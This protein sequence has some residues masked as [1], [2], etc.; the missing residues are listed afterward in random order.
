MDFKQMYLIDVSANV[1]KKGKFKYLSW[2]HAWK[3]FVEQCPDATYVVLKDQ[4]NKCYFGDKD[5]GY[6]VY[7]SVTVDKITHEMW[8]PVMDY[9]N[10]AMKNPTM[11]DINKAVMRCLV[12]NLA[13]FG[14]GLNL[15][16]GE[17]L[18]EEPD[19][20]TQ[21]KKSSTSEESTKE[22]TTESVFTFGKNS[23]KK[24]S[25]VYSENASYFKYLSENSK[26]LGL[27]KLSAQLWKYHEE[28]M[29]YTESTLMAYSDK[30]GAI[31]CSGRCYFIK[32]GITCSHKEPTGNKFHRE[33]TAQTL[34]NRE[35]NRE[36]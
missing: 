31:H 28:G 6:M 4:N 10:K 3:W 17:D 11:M 26:D 9:S 33:P 22:W 16:A 13:M 12:K 24:V 8:L 36:H 23:G 35:R 27:K 30:S 32:N 19:K 34:C 18:P 20:P 21:N 15:Y 7:T 1:E 25:E 14:L 5:I 2:S 29:L